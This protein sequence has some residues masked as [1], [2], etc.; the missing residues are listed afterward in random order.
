MTHTYDVYLDPGFDLGGLQAVKI[1]DETGRS[2]FFRETANGG[3]EGLF[4]ERT[5]LQF[6]GGTYYLA[7]QGRPKIRL[8]EFRT[9]RL[10][11]G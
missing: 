4:Y 6:T 11:S 8:F 1:M 3:Y 9:A 5:R 7:P 10:D 2:A